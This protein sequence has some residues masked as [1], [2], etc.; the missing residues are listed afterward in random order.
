M[1]MNNL[2]GSLVTG[3]K[4]AFFNQCLA[5]ASITAGVSCV[6]LLRLLKLKLQL[7]QNQREPTTVFWCQMN[8]FFA[9]G[10]QARF[11]V[12]AKLG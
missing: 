4:I 3:A 9:S 1:N 7:S 2:L 6:G 5:L 8:V 12:A 10:Q 11:T